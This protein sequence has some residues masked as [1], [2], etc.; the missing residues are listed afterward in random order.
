MSTFVHVEGLSSTMKTCSKCGVSQAVEQ[1]VKSARH[2]GGLNPWCSSCHRANAM[3][4]ARECGRMQPYRKTADVDGLRECSKCKARKPVTEFYKDKRAADGLKHQCKVCHQGYSDDWTK[5]NP[6]KRK[7]IRQRT[8]VKH[9][10]KLLPQARA[11]KKNNKPRVKA[12][13]ASWIERNRERYLAMMR[14]SNKRWKERNPEMVKANYHKRRALKRGALGTF[15]PVEIAA[16]FSQQKGRC[17]SPWCRISLKNGYHRDHIT[18]LAAGGSNFIENIQ[19]LCA[20]CNTRKGAK[21][22]VK[23]MQQNGYLI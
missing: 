20:P 14:A 21:D 11:W 13:L 4:L 7:E 2:A 23:H 18:P 22:P 19:L 5:R 8:H 12:V 9:R 3:R 1:F 17:A 16:L 10:D 15:T 6:E